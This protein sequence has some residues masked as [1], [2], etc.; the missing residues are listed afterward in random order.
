MDESLKQIK[1]FVQCYEV[2][3]NRAFSHNQCGCTKLAYYLYLVCTDVIESHSATTKC[4]LKLSNVT[5]PSEFIKEIFMLTNKQ[6]KG[7]IN[8]IKLNSTTKTELCSKSLL[9]V[10]YFT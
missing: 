5:L 8:K 1:L 7:H 9:Y 4:V 2:W 10:Y 3:I 6:G